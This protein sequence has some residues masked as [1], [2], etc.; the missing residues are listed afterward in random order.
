LIQKKGILGVYI[1]SKRT[2]MVTTIAFPELSFRASINHLPYCFYPH[3]CNLSRPPL[4]ALLLTRL[5]SRTP[6]SPSISLFLEARLFFLSVN[7]DFNQSFFRVIPSY[8]TR[9]PH[10]APPR[11]NMNNSYLKRLLLILSYSSALSFIR[12]SIL[13]TSAKRK[14]QKE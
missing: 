2:F 7:Q 6:S 4:V 14:W 5:L 1:F 10:L 8:C 11:S 3:H 13:Q 12:C 9:I